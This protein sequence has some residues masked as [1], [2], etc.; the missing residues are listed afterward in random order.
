MSEEKA[1]IKKQEDPTV[2][3]EHTAVTSDEDAEAENVGE[4]AEM[5]YQK[6]NFENSSAIVMGSE[7]FGIRK[8]TAEKCD[9]LI[10]L[11]DNRNFKSFNVAVATGIILSEVVRQR[12]C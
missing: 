10:N 12:K 3:N 2:E 7:E 8:K 5:S 6:C 9:L 11:S 4:H 1:E